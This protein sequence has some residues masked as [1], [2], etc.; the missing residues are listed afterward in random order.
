MIF[1][2]VVFP[3]PFLPRSAY[4]L[5]SFICNET[6]CK[7]LLSLYFLLMFFSSIFTI[8]T[9]FYNHLNE[10]FFRNEQFISFF[11]KRNNVMVIKFIFSF[12]QNNLPSFFAYK[13]TNTT[14]L[15]NNTFLD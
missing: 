10:L 1:I 15:G 3:A 5:G 2:K 8:H 13:H 6:W 11:F 7:T 4:I 14:P 12:C 9:S